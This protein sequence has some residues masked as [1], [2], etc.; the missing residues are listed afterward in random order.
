MAAEF[1]GQAAALRAQVEAEQRL[2]GLLAGLRATEQAAEA[3]LQVRACT[4]A[5]ATR[6]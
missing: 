2:G 6:S 3:E 4:F 5:L 1:G